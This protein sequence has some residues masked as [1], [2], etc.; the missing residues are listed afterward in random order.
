[1]TS[2]HYGSREVK[3]KVQRV[4]AIKQ[5]CRAICKE[6]STE[7]EAAKT[8]QA[9]FNFPMGVGVKFKKNPDGD[10]IVF[11]DLIDHDGQP[12]SF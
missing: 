11:G 7:E 5:R 12:I 2:E 1:M 10:R 6:A 3:E 9:E 8:I 4:E